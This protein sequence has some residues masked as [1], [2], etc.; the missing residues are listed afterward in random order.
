MVEPFVRFVPGQ[1]PYW[2]YS[3][4]QDGNEVLHIR[5]GAPVTVFLLNL[6]GELAVRRG[7]VDELWQV[8]EPW[9]L[10]C[11]PAPRRE[12][13]APCRRAVQLFAEGVASHH[14]E[15]DSTTTR[16]PFTDRE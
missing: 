3:T 2:K 16:T 11:V 13:D 6:I 14:A 12:T 4:D 15:R 1:R 7:L 5:D 10:A 9:K 8:L